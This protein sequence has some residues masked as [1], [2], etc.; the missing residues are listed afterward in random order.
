MLFDYGSYLATCVVKGINMQV[1][2]NERDDRC[3]GAEKIELLIG[4]LFLHH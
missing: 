2:G 3:Y 4:S 1:Y